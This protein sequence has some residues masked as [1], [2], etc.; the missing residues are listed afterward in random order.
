MR[1]RAGFTPQSGFTL[2]EAVIVIVITG[3]IGAVVAVFIRAPVQG[4]IDS[5]ARAELTDKAD[6]ALRRIA[7]DLR[8]AL[9][10]SVRVAAD[11]KY[12]ELLLTKTGGRYLAEE[13]QPAGGNVLKFGT[14]VNCATTPADCQFDVVGQ[15]PI[16]APQ[17]I[18]ADDSIVVYNLGPDLEAGNP[19]NAYGGGNRALVTSVNGNTI[20]IATNPFAAQG[21]PMSSPSQRF[22]VVSTPVTYFCDGSDA[23]GSG[24]LVRYWNYAIQ[25][26]QPT[27]QPPGSASALLATG[28]QSCRFDYAGLANIQSGLVGLQ[29]SMQ[30]PDS[31]SGTVTLSHQV[32]VDNTP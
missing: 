19:A 8:L 25:S 3:I 4:Y 13:D 6:T 24:Q 31:N 30:T 2:V 10:N 28:V 12:L 22:Q 21:P 11:G 23:G 27:A 14:A 29:I 16:G 26:A 7:R 32:H 9:P 15:M 5:A 20:T 18:V 1:E 17:T